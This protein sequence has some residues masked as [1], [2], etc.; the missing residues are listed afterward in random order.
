MSSKNAKKSEQ[1]K[2][3]Q[4]QDG[5]QASQGEQIQSPQSVTQPVS[6]GQIQPL[7]VKQVQQPMPQIE[8]AQAQPEQ[9]NQPTAVISPQA[10][11]NQTQYQYV[12]VNYSRKSNVIGLSIVYAISLFLTIG[13]PIGLFSMNG[14]MKDFSSEAN[15]YLIQV[16]KIVMPIVLALSVISSIILWIAYLSSKNRLVAKIAAACTLSISVISFVVFWIYLNFYSVVGFGDAAFFL[17]IPFGVMI[18][19][20]AWCI[21]VFKYQNEKPAYYANTSLNGQY[22]VSPQYPNHPP[23]QPQPSIQ[24]PGAA[25]PQYGPAPAEQN[26]SYEQQTVNQQYFAQPQAA[27]VQY[28]VMAQLLKGVKGWLAF[29]MVC[30]AIDGVCSV[31]LFFTSLLN[32]GDPSAVVSVTFMPII[33]VLTT[34]AVVLINLQK[35]LGKWLAVAALVVSFF[36]SASSAVVDSVVKRPPNTDSIISMTSTIIASGIS[37]GLLCLYFFVSRRVKETLVN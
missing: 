9:Q 17:P 7:Q 14:S 19:G 34:V 30:L 10:Y 31:G 12:Y 26:A 18:L 8:Q 32:L 21:N 36:Y 11:Q 37:M 2:S 28:V 20:I 35:K 13:L 25:D 33:A 6:G 29:F 5:A 23:Q 27:P 15:Y 1:R 16:V 3:N 24:Q 4:Q 22:V